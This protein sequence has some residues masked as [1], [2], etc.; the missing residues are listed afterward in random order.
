MLFRSR[1]DICI[2]LKPEVIEKN[3]V[4]IPLFLP[5]AEIANFIT[6][7]F[8]LSTRNFCSVKRNLR[9]MIMDPNN[10]DIAQEII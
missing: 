1:K 6:Q 9:L 7:I 4:T 10:A 8:Y 5:F 3:E 2:Y